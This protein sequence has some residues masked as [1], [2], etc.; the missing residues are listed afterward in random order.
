MNKFFVIF[1]PAA[2][3]EKSQRVQRFLEAKAQ[4]QHNL[5]LA[6]TD[7]PGNAKRLAA[8]AA[9]AGCDVIVAAGGDGTVNEVINGIV[10][11]STALAV[12]PLGTANVFA[13]ELGVPLDLDGAWAVVE[14]GAVREVDLGC[15]DSGGTRRYFAQL[16]GVGFDAWA[17][18]QASWELKKKIGPLSYVWAGFKAVTHPLG[19]VEVSRNGAGPCGRGPAVLI[20]NGRFYGGPFELF[21]KARLDDGRLDICVFE[22]GGYFDLLRYG[23][24][25]L[26]G[27]HTRLKDVQYFQA[28]QFDCTASHVGVPF[29]LDGEDAGD[30]PVRFTVAPRALRVMVPTREG[31]NDHVR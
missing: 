22:N 24:A 13:R 12:L 27:A 25:V 31:G 30:A 20:G 8:D 6:P 17:V 7:G 23:Q 21:P 10:G 16:A 9:A 29:E 2:R 15:A 11:L 3:G 14:R 18:R 26:R 5:T 4:A 1:N 19:D 28:E